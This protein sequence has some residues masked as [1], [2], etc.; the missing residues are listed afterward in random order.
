MEKNKLGYLPDERPSFWHAIIFAVQQFLVMLPATVL[1]QCTNLAFR[2]LFFQAVWQ[3][4]LFS[5]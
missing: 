4:F 2:Q 3:H 1:Q 5:Y